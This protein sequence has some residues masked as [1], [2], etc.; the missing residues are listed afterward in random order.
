MWNNYQEILSEKEKYVYD[1]LFLYEKKNIYIHTCTYIFFF[2]RKI[3]KKTGDIVACKKE[4][5]N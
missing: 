3:H 4:N 2:L 5:H 1:V